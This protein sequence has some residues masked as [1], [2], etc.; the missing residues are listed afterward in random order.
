MLLFQ[1]ACS[2]GIDLKVMHSGECQKMD[3]CA[4]LKCVEGA[5]CVPTEEGEPRQSII[6]SVREP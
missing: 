1:D 6:V 2:L 3:P 5:E 4:R